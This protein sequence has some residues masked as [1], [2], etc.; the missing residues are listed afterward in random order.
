M[1]EIKQEDVQTFYLLSCCLF[2]LFVYGV[3]LYWYVNKQRLER[4]LQVQNNINNYIIE[5]QV[6]SGLV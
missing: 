3:C 1:I 6:K 2:I 5:K 4:E